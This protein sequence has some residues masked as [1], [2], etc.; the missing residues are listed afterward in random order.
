MIELRKKFKIVVEKKRKPDLDVETSTL[1]M[2]RIRVNT[3]EGY[4]EMIEYNTQSS[5]E[6]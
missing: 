1:F 5:R 4:I 6:R 2:V 3:T